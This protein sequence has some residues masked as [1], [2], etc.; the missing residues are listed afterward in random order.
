MWKA[1]KI[2][3]D[4]A[5]KMQIG[6]GLLLKEFDISNPTEPTDEQIVAETTGD[7]SISCTPTTEDLFSDVNNAMT[8]TKE[9]KMITGWECSLGITLLSITEEMLA[10]SL[11]ASKATDDGKGIRPRMAYE[12]EDFKPL[13]WIGDMMGEDKLFVVAME[14]TLSTGGLSFT[15][16]NNGKGRLAVTLMPHASL[17]KPDHVPMAFYLL[18]KAEA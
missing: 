12:M 14:D 6:S 13:Y 10:L 3:A 1:K 11:G 2:S 18:E 7:Y 17:S 16:S 15:A 5:E 4:A 8:N 9:G